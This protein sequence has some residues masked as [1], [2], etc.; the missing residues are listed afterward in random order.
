MIVTN[1]EW[2][3]TMTLQLF[4]DLQIP[5]PPEC[6]FAVPLGADLD[7]FRAGVDTSEVRA[8]MA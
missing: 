3:R 2:T 6:V 5:M 7:R 8:N 1:S 4:D